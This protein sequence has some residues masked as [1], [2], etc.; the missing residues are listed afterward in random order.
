ML[1][2]SHSQTNNGTT[3]RTNRTSASNSMFDDDD[4]FTVPEVPETTNS[5]ESQ[6]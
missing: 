1:E 2:S 3:S 5:Q 4:D 6:G